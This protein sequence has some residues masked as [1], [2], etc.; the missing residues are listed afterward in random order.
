M[1][2]DLESE[3][4]EGLGEARERL[5]AGAGLR[6]EDQGAGGA[7]DFPVGNLHAGRL[8]H[9]VLQTRGSGRG[10]A[11]E[12]ELVL[13]RTGR[14]PTEGRPQQHRGRGEDARNGMGGRSRAIGPRG[15]RVSRRRAVGGAGLSR[16]RKASDALT[17]RPLI[18]QD[19]EGGRD[20][21]N[22]HVQS[23]DS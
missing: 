1:K 2:T 11:S 5:V 8:G 21:Q 7:W 17:P 3:T 9:I 6:D 18:G 23:G 12:A 16:V 22:S 13:E 15:S 20:R 14:I 19:G 10:H 4:V